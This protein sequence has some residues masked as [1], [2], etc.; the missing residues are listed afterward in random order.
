MQLLEEYVTARVN[1]AEDARRLAEREL[2]R[3]VRERGVVVRW[4]EAAEARRVVH[5]SRRAS[6][7]SDADAVVAEPDAGARPDAGTTPEA[8][9]RELARTGR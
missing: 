8:P 3:Q 9:A 5:R 6:R 2:L 4:R 1:A 7:V